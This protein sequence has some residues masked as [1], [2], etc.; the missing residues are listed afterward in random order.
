MGLILWTIDHATLHHGRPQRIHRS[1]A[2]LESAAVC[3]HC[4]QTATRDWNNCDLN[5]IDARLPGDAPNGLAI[6]HISP[7][8]IMSL[9][10][11]EFNVDSG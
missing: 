3:I 9:L 8:H 1:T 2:K 6:K 4:F 11:G 7:F 10:F 5:G